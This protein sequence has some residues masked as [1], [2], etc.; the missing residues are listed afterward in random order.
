MEQR[1][2]TGNLEQRYGR[3]RYLLNGSNSRIRRIQVIY[4]REIDKKEN[5]VEQWQDTGIPS[6]GRLWKKIHC[7]YAV[8]EYTV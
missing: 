8:P 1:Q 7:R 5:Y 3:Y 6:I 2:N 4:R